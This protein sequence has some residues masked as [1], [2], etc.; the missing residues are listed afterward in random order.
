VPCS[1]R[2][3]VSWDRLSKSTTN[4]PLRGRFTSGPRPVVVPSAWEV[5]CTH[6]GTVLSAPASRACCSSHEM[7]QLVSGSHTVSRASS[8]AEGFRYCKM[9]SPW[10]LCKIFSDAD[11]FRLVLRCHR[12]SNARAGSPRSFPINSQYCWLQWL[13]WVP[14][15][16]V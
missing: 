1:P 5:S 15:F 16:H 2:P 6:S 8:W 9:A 4:P 7:G 13:A 10:A 3:K 14:K 12:D 11:Y